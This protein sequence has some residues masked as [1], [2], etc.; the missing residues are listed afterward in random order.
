MVE[1]FLLHLWLDMKQTRL[2]TSDRCRQCPPITNS[3]GLNTA[4][5]QAKVG[6]RQVEAIC[7]Q[8]KAIC[9][10]LLVEL[11]YL[12]YGSMIPVDRWVLSVDSCGLNF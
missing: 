5:R 2:N 6:C 7:R 4:C 10:Q 11:L 1:G 9:R 3:R 8:M 12:G